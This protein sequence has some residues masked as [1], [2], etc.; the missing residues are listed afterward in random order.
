MAEEI[1]QAPKLSIVKVRYFSETTSELSQQEYTYYTED[2]LRLGDIVIV[3]VKDT[4]G[5]A[6]VSAIDVPETEI[7]A[8]KD[9]VKTISSGSVITADR[10]TTDNPMIELGLD[11]AAGSYHG[12]S[13]ENLE[14]QDLITLLKTHSVSIV[15][16]APAEDTKIKALFEE[17]QSILRFA[18]ARVITVNDDLK[19]ATEPGKEEK[20]MTIKLPRCNWQKGNCIHQTPRGR[21][22]WAK[23]KFCVHKSLSPE[24][25][26]EDGM[27]YGHYITDT[28]GNRKFF[29]A[30]CTYCQLSTGGLHSVNCPLYQSNEVQSPKVVRV[31]KYDDYGNFIKEL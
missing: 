31:F 11:L 27:I 24:A 5:K 18:E 21:C 12:E 17:S 7:A 16:T 8:F 3:P 23:K 20:T 22:D 1:I 29:S 30:G 25:V 15:K 26:K 4:S 13:T 10:I 2:P 28:A 6:K 14:A 9:K 19:P